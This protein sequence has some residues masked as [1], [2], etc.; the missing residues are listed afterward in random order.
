MDPVSIHSHTAQLI[1]RTII[2]SE[3][4]AFSFITEN[5]P[6]F[7]AGQFVSV[8]VGVDAQ[9]NPI[10]RS[11]SIASSPA[12][13]GTFELVV[14]T[15]EQ[16]VGTGFFRDLP[17]G[18]S[19]RFTGPLGFFVNEPTHSGDI[20]YV[21]TGT[22]IAPILPMVEEVVQRSSETGRILL[23][24]GVRHVEDF[25][26]QNWILSLEKS[27]A[28]FE[29]MLLVSRPREHFTGNAGRVITPVLSCLPHLR[30]PIFYLCGSGYMIRD[31]KTALQ[32]E[33]IDRKKQIRTEAF[34]DE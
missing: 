17:V 26:H 15:S 34:F 32:A 14:R 19:I 20:V 5:L 31:L 10:L 2:A 24:W 8:Q 3:T 28:R 9:K 1:R 27:S 12:N 29:S 33:G 21:A 23:F 25:F 7:Q 11:Y 30:Q 22:G 4:E 6:P 16:G 13:L 18:G